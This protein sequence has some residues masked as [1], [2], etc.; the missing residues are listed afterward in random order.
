MNKD[1]MKEDENR[2]SPLASRL[3]PLGDGE[4]E[5]AERESNLEWASGLMTYY[6]AG[7]VHQAS[8]LGIT[9]QVV[10]SSTVRCINVFDDEF[11]LQLLAMVKHTF[12]CAGFEVQVD[13]YTVVRPLQ[14]KPVDS[15]AFFDN[16]ETAP[17]A[18]A[19]SLTSRD[20]GQPGMEVA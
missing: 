7:S 13:P 17:S 11:C 16:V 19:M 12:E 3:P 20:G 5:R 4:I 1:D 15:P 9:F 6:A 8:D 2:E 14:L 10:S 18:P